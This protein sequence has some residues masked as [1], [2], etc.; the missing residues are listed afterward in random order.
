METKRALTVNELSRR[1]SPVLDL[2]YADAGRAITCVLGEIA[3]A[4]GEGRRVVLHD[5]G[6]FRVRATKARIGRNPK[7]GA[8]LQ[9]PARTKVGFRYTGKMMAPNH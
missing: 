2:S 3:Q 8:V 5:F 4:L 1:L 6:T 9:I 7:T